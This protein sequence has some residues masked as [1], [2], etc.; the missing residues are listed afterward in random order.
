MREVTI[1]THPVRLIIPIVSPAGD[2]LLLRVRVIP[3]VRTAG[4]LGIVPSAAYT[5]SE[6]RQ[7]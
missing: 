1:F 4:E 6:V 5:G 3:V 2:D 7:L